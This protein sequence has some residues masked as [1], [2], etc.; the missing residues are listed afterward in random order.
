MIVMYET[1]SNEEQ[2][3]VLF[4]ETKVPNDVQAVIIH[5]LFPYVN[6]KGEVIRGEIDYHI[7]IGEKKNIKQQLENNLDK[8]NEKALKHY[9]H[10]GFNSVIYLKGSPYQDGSLKIWGYGKDDM[11]VSDRIQLI[12]I[13]SHIQQTYNLMTAE[14]IEK[15]NEK[16]SHK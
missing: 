2:E 12:Q 3:W 11:I 13:V 1:E 14:I 15:V 7:A 5:Q 9:D 4:D 10:L 6:C 16:N 8:T